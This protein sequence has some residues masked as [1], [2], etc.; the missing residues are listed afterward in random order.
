MHGALASLCAHTPGNRMGGEGVCVRWGPAWLEWLLTSLS[1]DRAPRS[2]P[3]SSNN[4]LCRLQIHIDIP[5]MSPETLILQ[6]KV[7]E[8]SA[9]PGARWAGVQGWAVA[10]GTGAT[11]WSIW[12]SAHGEEGSQASQ[13]PRALCSLLLTADAPL[14]SSPF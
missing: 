1:M 3:V 8:V 10:A 4:K 12:P 6:P 5:R 2:V 9:G 11:D 7:T 13:G 14:L